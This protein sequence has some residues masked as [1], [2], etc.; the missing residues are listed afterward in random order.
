ML[1]RRVCL[2][3]GLDISGVN[4]EVLPSQWEYQVSKLD[5]LT[6]GW[7]HNNSVKGGAALK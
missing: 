3:A 5:C 6:N 4:G 7:A 2:V 1:L